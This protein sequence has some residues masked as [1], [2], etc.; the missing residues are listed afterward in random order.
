MSVA[1]SLGEG[2]TLIGGQMVLLHQSERQPEAAHAA[3]GAAQAVLDLGDERSQAATAG[4]A[5][6]V[7]TVS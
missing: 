1:G 4:L 5:L 2:W 7:P 3:P 6:L